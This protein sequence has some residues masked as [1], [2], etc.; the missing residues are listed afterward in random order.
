MTA[1][2][3]TCTAAGRRRQP[4]VPDRGP[5]PADPGDPGHD[6][7]QARLPRS[8]EY[9]AALSGAVHATCERHE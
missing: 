3:I 2:T 1:A 6:S 9:T 7:D 4:G 5:G 8:K